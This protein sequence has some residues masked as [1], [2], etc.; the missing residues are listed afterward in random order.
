MKTKHVP[1]R[2]CLGCDEKKNK[3][4]F[5]R[6]GINGERL[7][8]DVNG[9]L[10]GRG[11]YVCRQ[12]ECITSLLRKKGKLSYALRISV[13]HFEEEDFLC[14]ILRALESEG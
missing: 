8:M 5:L 3:G 4:E 10:P 9:K 11:A 13:P 6:I 7:V 1:I 2:S 12:T 14:G